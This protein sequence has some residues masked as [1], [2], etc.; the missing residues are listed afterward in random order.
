VTDEIQRLVL[1]MGLTVMTRTHWC[2]CVYTQC[3]SN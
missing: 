3:V 1:M 2:R